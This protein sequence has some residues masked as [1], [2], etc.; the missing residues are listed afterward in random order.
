MAVKILQGEVGTVNIGHE[1]IKILSPIAI[2]FHHVMERRCFHPE[3][4]C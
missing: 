4:A 3:W 2:D 1:M